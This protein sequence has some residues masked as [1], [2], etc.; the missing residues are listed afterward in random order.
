MGTLWWEALGADLVSLGKA[1]M[2]PAWEEDE[3][4]GKL[5]TWVSAALV[6]YTLPVLDGIARNNGKWYHVGD[7]GWLYTKPGRRRPA[8]CLTRSRAPC[9]WGLETMVD[10]A[11]FWID[12]L[13]FIPFFLNLIF[14]EEPS[15]LRVYRLGIYLGMFLVFYAV[16]YVKAVFVYLDLFPDASDHVAVTMLGLTINFAELGAVC[17]L[18]PKRNF[19]FRLVVVVGLLI[20]LLEGYFSFYTAAYFHNP[21]DSVLGYFEGWAL[22]SICLRGLG[23]AWPWEGIPFLKV[24]LSADEEPEPTG[25]REPLLPEAPPEPSVPPPAPPPVTEPSPPALPPSE[26]PAQPPEPAAATSSE[27]PSAAPTG[28]PEAAPAATIEPS[29]AP[30]EAPEPAPKAAPETPKP[31]AGVA[32]QATG[33]AVQAG[34]HTPRSGGAGPL[35]PAVAEPVLTPTKP[36]V[37]PIGKAVEAATST[38][39]V[40]SP[41]PALQASPEMFTPRTQWLRS[42]STGSGWERSGSHP[43]SGAGSQEA[44][45]PLGEAHDATASSSAPTPATGA[46]PAK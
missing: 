27:A 9:Y 31:P 46:A 5:R 1:H 22:A 44:L 23:C 33:V 45:P 17:T 13:P 43:H 40:G 6:L 3:K 41:A 36:P 35:P 16:Y 21:V 11:F 8:D 24:L 38:T 25:P 10:D 34:A 7:G 15:R 14:Y 28:T 39:P 19:G 26:E 30:A 4:K 20:L 37:P 42:T 2:E 18:K 12:L 32:V 29:T